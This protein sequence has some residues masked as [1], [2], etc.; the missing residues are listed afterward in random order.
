MHDHDDFVTALVR[1]LERD[2]SPRARHQAV[3]ALRAELGISPS[4]AYAVLVRA[5][6]GLPVQQ[7][8]RVREPVHTPLLAG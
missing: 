4:R 1:A 3:M 6:A 5:T 8:S 7:I 2:S